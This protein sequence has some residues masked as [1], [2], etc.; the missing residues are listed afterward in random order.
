MTLW[1]CWIVVRLFLIPMIGGISYKRRQWLIWGYGDTRLPSLRTNGPKCHTSRAGM[2]HT[3][4]KCHTRAKMSHSHVIIS[5]ITPYSK[6]IH[7]V[8]WTASN[9]Y[10]SV[11]LAFLTLNW[12]QLNCTW[13]RHQM[14]TFFALLAFVRGIHLSPV[15]SP[16]KGQ[17][18]RALIFCIRAWTNDEQTTQTPVIRDAISLIMT[19]M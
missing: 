13:W 11:W 3:G 18:R 2:S 9:T 19:S 15:D 5:D 4:P 12:R 16:Y 6:T 8:L 14:E 7:K 10:V 17:W 1:N